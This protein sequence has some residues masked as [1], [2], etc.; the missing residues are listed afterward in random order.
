VLEIQSGSSA[1]AANGFWFVLLLHHTDSTR[2]L[3]EL[4]TFSAI[5]QD[6]KS[7]LKNQ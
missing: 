7:A 6:T 1:D 5:N 3:L 2:K 4:K